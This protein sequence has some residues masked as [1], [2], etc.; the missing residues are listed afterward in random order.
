MEM[1][2]EAQELLD[3]WFLDSKEN[4]LDRQFLAEDV[5]FFKEQHALMTEK[6]RIKA[7]EEARLQRLNAIKLSKQEV[8]RACCS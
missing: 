4:E 2:S 5:I 8:S 6:S 1:W 3:E 7:C